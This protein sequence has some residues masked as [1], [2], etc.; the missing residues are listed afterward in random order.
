MPLPLTLLLCALPPSTDLL[1][2]HRYHPANAGLPFEASRMS[3]AVTDLSRD[4][5]ED[6]LVVPRSTGQEYATRFLLGVF[7]DDSSTFLDGVAEDVAAA[8]GLSGIDASGIAY[9]VFGDTLRRFVGDPDG[10]L[11]ES[12]DFQLPS[13]VGSSLRCVAAGNGQGERYVAVVSGA[14]PATVDILVDDGQTLTSAFPSFTVP[15]VPVDARLLEF[16]AVSS[17]EPTHVAVL[18]HNAVRIYDFQGQVVFAQA[19]SFSAWAVMGDLA[20]GAPDALALA[21]TVSGGTSITRVHPV[22]GQQ[23]T[24]LTGWTVIGLDGGDVDEDGIADLAYCTMN[25]CTFGVLPNESW[26]MPLDP[27]NRY[28]AHEGNDLGMGTP[29]LGDHDHDG[30]VDLLVVADATVYVYESGPPTEMGGYNLD[31]LPLSQPAGEGGDGPVSHGF[32]VFPPTSAPGGTWNKLK[33]AVYY[34][35]Y[36]PGNFNASTPLGSFLPTQ[37]QPYS[38]GSTILYVDLPAE[39]DAHDAYFVK[40]W[41]VDDLHLPV[42]STPVSSY[43]WSAYPQPI[44]FLNS[45]ENWTNS[46]SESQVGHV[47]SHIQMSNCI[48]KQNI[49]IVRIPYIPPP[50]PPQGT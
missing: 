5:I 8:P 31:L 47:C 4:G 1:H 33:W 16:D 37:S 49:G 17:N 29:L 21:K 11:V 19:G 41:L 13:W 42:R 10:A 6:L 43:V 24:V 23:T 30:D 12:T 36:D 34:K 26:T 50:I 44:Y 35:D 45:P 48:P 20:D 14:S 39:P 7:D 25:P 2:L 32:E 15:G 9:T 18:V 22:H 28:K 46:T 40:F 27:D 38:G 3:L